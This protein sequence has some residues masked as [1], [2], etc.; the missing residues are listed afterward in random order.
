[1]LA[2]LEA[3]GAATLEA[4]AN[5]IGLGAD[6]PGL[7]EEALRGGFAEALVVQARDDPQGDFATNGLA[8][9]HG[10]AGPGAAFAAGNAHGQFVARHQPPTVEAAQPAKRIGGAAAEHNRHVDASRHRQVHAGA[11]LRKVKAQHLPGLHR[12][13]GVGVHFYAVEAG[14]HVGAADRDQRVLL[15]LKFRPQQRAFQRRCTGRVAH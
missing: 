7:G 4:V 2:R 14:C 15:E 8:Q 6:G 12:E 3:Q 9:G 11:R 10:Q 5:A 1:M 13:R